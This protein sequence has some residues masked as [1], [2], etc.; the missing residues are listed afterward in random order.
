MVAVFLAIDM[1]FVLLPKLWK[2]EASL[3]ITVKGTLKG[4]KVRLD[5]LDVCVHFCRTVNTKDSG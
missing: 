4:G 2:L 1:C 3:R 5:R